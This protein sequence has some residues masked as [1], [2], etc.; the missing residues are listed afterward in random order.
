MPVS[1]TRYSTAHDAV[2]FV[3]DTCSLLLNPMR[4]FTCTDGQYCASIALHRGN[5]PS[6]LLHL[7]LMLLFFEVCCTRI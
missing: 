2:S 1:P 6:L 7:L 4:V 3:A 5:P